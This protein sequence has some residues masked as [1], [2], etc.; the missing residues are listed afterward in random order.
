M[1]FI[2]HLGHGDVVMLALAAIAMAIT[3]LCARA[4]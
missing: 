4:R 2:G 1:Q 3:L